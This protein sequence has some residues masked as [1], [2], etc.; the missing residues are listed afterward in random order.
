MTVAEIKKKIILFLLIL[1]FIALSSGCKPFDSVEERLDYD[2]QVWV[3]KKTG[4]NYYIYV[5]GERF[6]ITPRLDKNGKVVITK[7]EKNGSK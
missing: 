1:I 7:G 2:L 6:G 5:G 4:V 3:D